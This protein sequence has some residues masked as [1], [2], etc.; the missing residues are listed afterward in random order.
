MTIAFSFITSLHFFKM[1][2]KILNMLI[3]KSV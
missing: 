1:L 2:N 3:M